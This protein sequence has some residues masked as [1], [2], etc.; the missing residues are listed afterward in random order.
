MESLAREW[1][2]LDQDFVTRMEI[3]SL[4]S[5]GDERALEERLKTS[6]SIEQVILQM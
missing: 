3:Q 6:K 1:L 2:R 4:L 5:E